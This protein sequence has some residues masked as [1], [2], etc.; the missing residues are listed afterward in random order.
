MRG[1]HVDRIFKATTE[2]CDEHL[3]DIEFHDDVR[4]PPAL[5]ALNAVARVMAPLNFCEALLRDARRAHRLR[6]LG[7]S[8]RQRTL[9]RRRQ[10]DARRETEPVS[11]RDVNGEQTSSDGSSAM[12]VTGRRGRRAGRGGTVRRERVRRGLGGL[13]SELPGHGE[14]ERTRP[15]RCGW[16]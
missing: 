8:T 13:L 4:Q 2:R 16:Q 6:N 7:L 5:H 3:V 9:H 1:V 12:R 15:A 10:R 11:R 14:K